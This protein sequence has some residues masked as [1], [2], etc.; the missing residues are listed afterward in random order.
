[1][2]DSISRMVIKIGTALV[3]EPDGTPRVDWLKSLV[4]DIIALR[5]KGTEVIVV[6]SGAVALGKP[7][8]GLAGKNGLKLEQKQAAASCG[9]SVLTELYRAYLREHG[10]EAAQILL[11]IEDSEHRRRYLN[12][13]NTVETLLAAGVVPVINENDAVAT[14]EL[15]VGDNDRL[16]ARVAVMLGAE[17]LVLLSDVDGLYS[18]DPSQD[19]TAEHI[20]VVKAITPEI[21]AMAGDAVSHAGSGG[22]VTKLAAAEIA[23]TGGCH[24]VITRGE[25]A[26]PLQALNQ[27]ARHTLIKAKETPHN[28]RKHWIVTGLVTSGKVVVD[29]GAETALR[30]GKSLLPAGVK[31][32]E[33]E[34]QRGDAV[35]IVT[36]DGVEIGRGL[37]AYNAEDARRIAGHNSKDIEALLGFSGRDALIHRDDLV[38]VE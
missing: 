23:I 27:S 7:A 4:A 17:L 15:R 38:M 19:K 16:A 21:I 32:V 10:V 11:T 5:A 25:V 13:R 30:S 20:P 12:A 18:A 1:M 2:L 9:Q 22:M 34:F 33:G 3:V 24:T 37:S 14:E 35:A 31:T 36:T 29:V 6:S 8:L 26:H 28:A